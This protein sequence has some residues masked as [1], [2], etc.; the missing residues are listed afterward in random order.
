[1]VVIIAF[2]IA[3]V[4]GML[5][6]ALRDRPPVE[7]LDGAMKSGG[8]TVPATY[9]DGSLATAMVQ[10]I[11][12]AVSTRVNAVLLRLTPEHWLRAAE[13]KMQR[14][15]EDNSTAVA[16]YLLCWA[17]LIGSA[18]VCSVL[19]LLLPGLS[20]LARDLLIF[21]VA[22]VTLAVPQYSLNAQVSRRQENIRFAL[23]DVTDLL[24]VSSEA[25]LGIDGAV[26]TVVRRK[27]GPLAEEFARLLLEIRLGGSREAAWNH[28]VDR[29]GVSELQ[30]LVASL[31]DAEQTG[32][33]IANT[34]R[35][36]SDVMRVRRSLL[37]RQLAATLPIKMLFPL[38]FFILPALFVVLL[39]PGAI[40]VYQAM[41]YF[42]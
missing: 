23:P 26:A 4:I 15:G 5:V 37:I 30:G 32:V 35:A 10:R 16:A 12:N 31:Q 28:L 9:L 41:R 36:Q 22:V 24:A 17:I 14:L 29:V 33:S 2:L 34:L 3:V 8:L 11:T 19:A 25:G 1:M 21:G 20:M 7:R 27:P 6:H 39:G 40:S 13:L 38:I 18:I 42:E